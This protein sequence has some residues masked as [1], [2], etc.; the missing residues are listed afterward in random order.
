QGLTKLRMLALDGSSVTDAGLEHLKGLTGLQ[1]LS[2]TNTG[3][4]DAGLEH[5]EG[6]TELQSLF[7]K[8]T[9]IS[10]AGLEHLKGLTGLRQLWLVQTQVS[11]AAARKLK[12]ALPECAISL[13]ADNDIGDAT[14]PNVDRAAAEWVLELG[15][16]VEIV[17]NGWIAQ[18][19]GL[20]QGSF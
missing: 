10:D 5:L 15:G 13:A 4:T 11:E 7:L 14:D 6:L 20:P 17:E 9:S 16:Q 2:L 12:A 3:I 1:Y 18:R 8:N 19:S